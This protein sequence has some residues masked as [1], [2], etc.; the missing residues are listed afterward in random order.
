MRFIASI[1]SDSRWLTF[2]FNAPIQ[3]F[4]V[5]IQSFRLV[6]EAKLAWGD[7]V[8]LLGNASLE[9]RVA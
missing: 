3:M 5:F 2:S 9:K 8:Y 7:F 6:S 4:F 1:L